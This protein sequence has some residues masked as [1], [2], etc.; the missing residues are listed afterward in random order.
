MEA[1]VLGCYTIIHVHEF[2]VE[3]FLSHAFRVLLFYGQ[4]TLGV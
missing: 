3:Q 1:G 2:S 4:F